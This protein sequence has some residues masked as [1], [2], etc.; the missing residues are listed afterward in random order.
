[1]LKLRRSEDKTLNFWTYLQILEVDL[2]KLPLLII[3]ENHKK[4]TIFAIR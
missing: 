4:I 1:M 3:P 2:N